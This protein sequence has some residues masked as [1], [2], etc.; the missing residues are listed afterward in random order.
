MLSFN[1]INDFRFDMGE[2]ASITSKGRTEMLK[3]NR[4]E[5]LAYQYPPT[6]DSSITGIHNGGK[7]L[8]IFNHG[9]IEMSSHVNETQTPAE[10]LGK[11]RKF[12]DI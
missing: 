12:E 4:L 7:I 2:F 3:M 6:I 10:I 9:N 5:I 8:V 11:L 1:Q